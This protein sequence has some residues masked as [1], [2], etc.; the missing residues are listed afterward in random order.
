MLMYQWTLISSMTV[1]VSLKRWFE[2][3]RQYGSVISRVQLERGCNT[4]FKKGL[5]SVKSFIQFCRIK[6]DVFLVIV[7]LLKLIP[8]MSVGLITSFTLSDE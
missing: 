4:H 5:Q 2:S 7:L 6:T 3:N 1:V 8:V